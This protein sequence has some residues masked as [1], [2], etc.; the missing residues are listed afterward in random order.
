MQIV[1][2]FADVIGVNNAEPKPSTPETE[3]RMR[4]GPATLP[5]AA[6]KEPSPFREVNFEELGIDPFATGAKRLKGRENSRDRTL[7]LVGIMCGV[8]ICIYAAGRARN[9]ASPVPSSNPPSKG[10]VVS[11][12]ANAPGNGAGRVEKGSD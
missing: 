10:S 6:A 11:A 2:G 4:I 7:R 1:P 8:A 12:E 5:R 9:L 3:P